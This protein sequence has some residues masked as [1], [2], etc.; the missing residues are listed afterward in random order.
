MCAAALNKVFAFVLAALPASQLSSCGGNEGSFG[1]QET[2]LKLPHT[3]FPVRIYG[4][5]RRRRAVVLFASGDGG[6]KAF[7]DKICRY[8]ASLGFCVVGWDCRKFADRGLYDQGTLASGFA[9]A[10]DEARHGGHDVQATGRS[11]G[12]MR[13]LCIHRGVMDALIAES[14]LDFQRRGLSQA[15][16][17]NAPLAYIESGSLDSLEEKL[18]RYLFER[19]E[20]YYGYKAL[21]EF[22]RNSIPPGGVGMLPTAVLPTCYPRLPP[23]CA[24]ICQ[25][26]S[27]NA[28]DPERQQT[29][30]RTGICCFRRNPCR[31]SIDDRADRR[32]GLMIQRCSSSHQLVGEPLEALE[33]FFQRAVG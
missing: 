32:H 3:S 13:H 20:T 28:F 6:W 24:C 31:I 9:A 33:P 18:I 21:F 1:G 23:S 8:L 7:E 16:L 25:A 14:L 11:I 4:T 26:V 30:S 12:L 22:K 2:V 19:F 27:S 17:G 15:S 5:A 29:I 10:L